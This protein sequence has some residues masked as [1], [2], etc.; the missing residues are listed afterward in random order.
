M[1]RL[2]LDTSGYLASLNVKHPLH[3]AVNRVLA[4]VE[5]P[6]V[7]SPMVFAEIDYLV[8][9]TLGVDAEIAVIDDLTSGAYEPAALDIDDLRAG[10]ALVARYRDLKVGLTD[11][12]NVVLA[13]RHATNEVLTTNQRHYRAMVPLSRQHGAF[14]LLPYDP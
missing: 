6:P 14:R 11:A 1:A 10:R 5:Q 9:T 2:I 12:V 8:L 7:L 3:D 13:D 4:G